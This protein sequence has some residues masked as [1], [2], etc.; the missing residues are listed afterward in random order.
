[1]KKA[2]ISWEELFLLNKKEL[3]AK[4]LKKRNMLSKKDVFD[5]SESI[6]LKLLESDV[7]KSSSTIL[8]YVNVKNEVS[9][10]SFINK[11]IELKKKDMHS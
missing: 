6:S 9:T 11:C 8:A 5:M 4:I 3:R 10:I 2:Y 1:M 7:F